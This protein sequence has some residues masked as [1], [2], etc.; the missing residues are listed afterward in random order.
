MKTR[1]GVKLIVL[2]P[3]GQV[4]MLRRSATDERRSGTWDFPGGGVERNESFEKGAIRELVEET[5]IQANTNQ[6]K[7]LYAETEF[8]KPQQV[9]I[10]RM[11]FALKLKTDK[12]VTLSFE[13]EDVQWVSAEQALIDFPHPMY[14]KA[15]NYALKHRLLA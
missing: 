10:T 3:Q 11:L 4:L 13:H 15:L 1:K 8:Y 5:G 14:G 6:L 2:N 9:N 7:L 12:E